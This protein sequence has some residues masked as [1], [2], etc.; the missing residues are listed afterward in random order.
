[1]LS[2]RPI[3]RSNASM[4]C[5][6]LAFRSDRSYTKFQSAHAEASSARPADDGSTSRSI[7]A[8]HR[9]TRAHRVRR[10]QDPT[11]PGEPGSDLFSSRVEL[12]HTLTI[13]QGCEECMT[14]RSAVGQGS[15]PIECLAEIVENV[16]GRLDPD[17][18][19]TRS[20]GTS[21]SDPAA[22]AWVITPGCSIR[23]ST[24]RAIRRVRTP[25]SWW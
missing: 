23:D 5:C 25:A 2:R 3:Q 22:G 15:E 7:V 21:S 11:L 12:H 13:G 17:L 16:L 9:A 4:S 19:R 6:R 1:M 18:S 10:A 14:K 8:Q 24:D 20:A